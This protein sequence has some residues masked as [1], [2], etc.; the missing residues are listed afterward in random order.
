ML[1]IRRNMILRKEKINMKKFLCAFVLVCM[2]MSCAWADVPIDEEHF[3]DEVFRGLVS[4]SFDIDHDGVLSYQEAE[5]ILTINVQ[6]RGIKDLKGIEY[7]TRISVLNC[8]SNDL[9]KLDLS[10]NDVSGN[11][12]LKELYCQNN[13]LTDLNV[14]DNE[15]L[16]VLNCSN[17][18]LSDLVVRRNEALIELKCSDNRLTDLDVSNNKALEVLDCGG[19]RL[20]GIDVASNDVLVE[21]RV[22]GNELTDIDVSQNTSLRILSVALNQLTAIDLSANTA[23]TE[24]AC[25]GNN[26]ISLDLRK[27]TALTEVKC[28]SNQ[29]TML[30]ISGCSELI[31]LICYS[32]ELETLDL[33]G[34]PKLLQLRCDNNH[35]AALD[36]S[37]N[38]SINVEDYTSI[39]D[40]QKRPRI[41]VM[42][43]VRGTDT[44]DPYPYTLNFGDYMSSSEVDN[45]VASSVKAADENNESIDVSYASGIARFT[46]IP[47]VVSYNYSTRLGNTTMSVKIGEAGYLT[48]TQNSHVYRLFTRGDTWVNSKNRCESIGGHL[49][50]INNDDERKL[51]KDLL[52][53]ARS[54][55]DVLNDDYMCWLGGYGEPD[56]DG[57][58]GKWV[59]VIA[60]EDFT[61]P[62]IYEDRGEDWYKK[63][64][65]VAGY[66]DPG[67]NLEL[68]LVGY[69]NPYICEWEPTT[70]TFQSVDVMYQIWSED[71]KAYLGGDKAYG[72]IPS[73]VSLV[74]LKNNPPEKSSTAFDYNP[75]KYDP[76]SKPIFPSVK[77]QDKYGTCWSFASIGALEASYAVQFDTQA[78]DLSE[79]HQAWYAFNNPRPE[80]NIEQRPLDPSE[81]PV[82]DQGGNQFVS[83][84]FLSGTGT[85]AESDLP[86]NA[87]TI[88]ALRSR[89]TSIRD[90]EK[91]PHPA[92]LREAYVL[93][94]ITAA[95]RD[96]TKRLT[97]KYGAVRVGLLYSD[98]GYNSDKSAYY[99]PDTDR[100]NHAVQIVGWDDDYPQENFLRK[101]NNKG[102]WLM[103]NSWGENWG[104]KGYFWVSY[105]QF[106]TNS[107]VFIAD[108]PLEGESAVYG[109]GA[110]NPNHDMRTTWTANMFHST[111]ED[112]IKEVAFYT[113]DNNVPY[114]IYINN[115][116]TTKPANP[117]E[118]GET[119]S[120]KGTMP[121]AGYHTVRL[122]KEEP[123]GPGD[124]FSVIL[125]IGATSDYGAV[126]AVEA[127]S[128]STSEVTIAGK[129]YFAGTDVNPGLDD[130]KDA[131][132]VQNG[133]Y[134]T[135]I[136]VFTAVSERGT[137]DAP[138]IT[139][140]NLSNGT[141]GKAYAQTLS[142][143][144][145]I[146]VTWYANRLP[147]GISVEGNKLV[148][149][150]TKA[151]TYNVEIIA[152]NNAG[153]NRKTLE[154]VIN[155]S[156]DPSD[157]NNNND[158]PGNQPNSGSS[159]GGGGCEALPFS[160]IAA[161]ILAFA[162]SK[163]K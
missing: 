5:S 102:A 14:R 141:V 140:S 88:S 4:V 56:D 127:S 152:D 103:K 122:D 55:H 134:D 118:P 37:G 18:Q 78:P 116:G 87:S 81:D 128:G 49:M 157:P 76:R 130:W 162:V 129:S 79:L 90:P 72:E 98:I 113:R 65:Y 10:G 99:L 132:G 2:I 104:D 51:A 106:L 142:A 120:Q 42:K 6:S 124:Y 57:N 83:I 17:N 36:L 40:G 158:N 147:D 131:S 67:N 125:K 126:Q 136:R 100:S 66:T 163:K 74:H 108:K 61:S 48:V 3:P 80:R 62:V 101:P 59:W 46:R 38:L 97:K 52:N 70:A 69:A 53:K 86:Y 32:N 26:L 133:K 47:E 60:S 144:S 75:P 148:G 30:D 115:H 107:A 41:N 161:A 137:F 149:I 8:A 63:G 146:S 50:T 7:F 154:L 29:L 92:V 155:S 94:D 153:A 1:P 159:G 156:T 150:P 82:L 77:D 143:T 112:T 45:I 34:S 117:G 139:T 114:E 58:V 135:S 138:T 27:N 119:P 89:N 151:G 68:E 33:S 105:E 85:A 64:P 96:D 31:R 111:G 109:R 110:T 43:P 84:Y 121:Y 160:A 21:L 23:L 54:E 13:K 28:E 9:E 24:F 145:S 91:Y 44:V 93:G 25:G 22:G 20:T 35:L 16:R 73:P 19:N 95:N 39:I 15:A 123:I 12:D 11:D 71:P